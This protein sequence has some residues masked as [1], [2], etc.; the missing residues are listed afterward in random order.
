MKSIGFTYRIPRYI[1]DRQNYIGFTYKSPIT[2]LYLFT[3]IDLTS[4]LHKMFLK[5]KHP[6]A[7]NCMVLTLSSIENNFFGNLLKKKIPV[8]MYLENLK[9]KIWKWLDHKTVLL[10]LNFQLSCVFWSSQF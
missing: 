1:T 8:P 7:D 2:Y 6:F 4:F 5:I 9:V 3:V 10:F